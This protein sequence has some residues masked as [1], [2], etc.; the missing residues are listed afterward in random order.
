[1]APAFVEA[2]RKAPAFH[3]ILP[4][5]LAES[6]LLE[7][8]QEQYPVNKTCLQNHEHL[9]TSN[10]TVFLQCLH[11]PDYRGYSQSFEK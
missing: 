11:V 3:I 1:M 2:K 4:F 5:A 8:V 7:Q 9:N 6:F 10:L